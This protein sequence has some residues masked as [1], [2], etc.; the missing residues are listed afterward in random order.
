ML[1]RI[2]YQK[3]KSNW[4]GTSKL[5]TSHGGFCSIKTTTKHEQD[6]Y[7]REQQSS[8][9][10]SFLWNFSE[11]GKCRQ[12]FGSSFQFSNV[13]LSSL[14]KKFIQNKHLKC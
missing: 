3:N 10:H 11:C 8:L 5:I 6:S 2:N 1:E 9:L 13:I 4:S 7:S 12:L 14:W